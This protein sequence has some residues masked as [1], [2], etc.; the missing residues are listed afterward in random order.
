MMFC[1]Q[2]GKQLNDGAKFCSGC[3][4]PVAAVPTP[5]QP[6]PVQHEPVQPTTPVQP[7]P[8]A[9]QSAYTTYAAAAVAPEKKKSKKGLVIGIIAALVAVAVLAC[10]FVFWI[11][12]SFL[13]DEA[14]YHKALDTAE[15]AMSDKTYDQAIAAYTNALD[16]AADR[17]QKMTVYLARAAANKAAENYEAAIE[18][19]EAA[20]GIDDE[21]KKVWGLLADAYLAMGDAEK[22]IEVLREGYEAT[23]AS[24]LLDKIA[25]I[26]AEQSSTGNAPDDEQVVDRPGETTSVEAIP[27]EPEAGDTVEEYVIGG[28]AY[29]ADTESL[30]LSYRDLYDEDVQVISNFTN[31]IHL[32]LEGNHITDLSFLEGMTQLKYL[33]LYD[34]DVSDISVLAQ[35]H[36]LEDLSLWCNP[37]EDISP[38]AGLTNLDHLDLDDTLVSDVSPL[39]GLT[40]LESLYVSGVNLPADAWDQIAA[41]LP[42]FDYMASGS[43]GNTFGFTELRFGLCTLIPYE[44]MSY[45]P[46]EEFSYIVCEMLSWELGIDPV[47]VG[48]AEPIVD[49]LAALQAGEVDCAFVQLPVEYNADLLNAYG[50]ECTAP[51]VETSSGS[52]AICVRQGDTAMLD[53]L[54]YAIEMMHSDGVMEELMA[55]WEEFGLSVWA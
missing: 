45:S 24:S 40:N 29:P 49:I 48:Y 41:A 13:S 23:D 53:M 1:P 31:L 32:G 16:Y 17:D 10:L 15:T 39:F 46:F 51:V 54:N 19:Y 20:L 47:P 43:P 8:V 5:A 30:S 14:K 37:V 2:C 36:Q 6:A 38:L 25:E 12:P 42:Q 7:E 4:S 33:Y 52:L 35:L 44:Y 34:N 22:A 21:Q 27:E 26:E 50:V 11:Q 3:G 18:D 55:I 9:A 28:V